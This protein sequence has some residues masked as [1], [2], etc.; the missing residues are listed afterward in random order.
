[1]R[2][3]RVRL[4]GECRWRL[5]GRWERT[6]DGAVTGDE[7]HLVIAHLHLHEGLQ[8]PTPFLVRVDHRLTTHPARGCHDR[9][10]RCCPVESLIVP[11][12]PK[13]L[14]A[15]PVSVPV[16]RA[17]LLAAWVGYVPDANR[18]SADR[19]HSA[20]PSIVE[21]PAGRADGVLTHGGVGPSSSRRAGSRR[22]G[23][24][25]PAIMSAASWSVRSPSS[26]RA[27]Q[28]G[29][30]LAPPWEGAL[31]GPPGGCVSVGDA[32][33]SARLSERMHLGSVAH[34]RHSLERNRLR[35]QGGS[36]VWGVPRSG[37]RSA[38]QSGFRRTSDLLLGTR[39]PTY[40]GDVG[41]GC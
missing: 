27:W 25:S 16:A 12:I 32:A 26:T 23:F 2:Q 40:V 20:H 21:R 29:C 3:R 31:V 4:E 18:S 24:P 41:C 34:M 30:E 7:R 11:F 19:V 14:A 28:A 6:G 17:T 5:A 8:D 36:P 13:L 22:S 39:S 10:E 35:R 15:R 1:M 33:R 38:P 37:G 9:V